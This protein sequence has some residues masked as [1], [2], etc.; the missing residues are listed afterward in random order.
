LYACNWH[1]AI[2]IFIKKGGLKMIKTLSY[3][4]FFEDEINIGNTY[5]Y[6]QLWDGNNGDGLELFRSG[7]I[8]VWDDEIEDYKIVYFNALEELE[9]NTDILQTLVEVI[10]II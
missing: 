2:K 8:A 10:N 5:Y 1:T 9:E 6:G 3:N 7:S 4:G